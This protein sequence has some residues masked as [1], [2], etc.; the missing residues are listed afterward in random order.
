LPGNLGK[1]E[2]HFP[3]EEI[4]RK[5]NGHGHE[6]SAKENIPCKPFPRVKKK[7]RLIQPKEN[8]R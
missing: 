7:T 1:V 6:E 4:H 3:P 2:V 8:A 5:Q